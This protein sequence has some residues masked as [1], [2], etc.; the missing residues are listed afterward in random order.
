MSTTTNPN[1]P[2]ALRELEP[3]EAATYDKRTGLYIIQRRWEIRGLD[4]AGAISAYGPDLAG[5]SVPLTFTQIYTEDGVTPVTMVAVARHAD[6]M[7]AKPDGTNFCYLTVTY[8]GHACLS[9]MS[10]TATTTAP[11][12]SGDGILFNGVVSGHMEFGTK[13][14]QILVSFDRD[15]TGQRKPIGTAGD[16]QGTN[17]LVPNVRMIIVQNMSE[18]DYYNRV[19]MIAGLV[20]LVNE[21]LWED[22]IIAKKG[23][24]FYQ[25]WEG[26]WLYLGAQ[27]SQNRDGTMTLQHQFEFDARQKPV[28]PTSTT[29]GNVSPLFGSAFYYHKYLWYAKQTKKK[30]LTSGE[31]MQAIPIDPPYYATI[32][33]TAGPYVA[34]GYKFADLFSQHGALT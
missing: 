22:P 12:G 7:A 18:V 19:P 27:V 8:E 4:W 33:E 30:T 3:R 5:I 20:G 16:V 11:N 34:L 28:D 1:P 9:P 17:R 29:A 10:G 14:E 13:S 26:M 24:Y 15:A 2:V 32:Y 21:N 25:W 6:K 23:T 31:K